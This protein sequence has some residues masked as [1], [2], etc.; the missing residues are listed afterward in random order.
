MPRS[1][2]RS[3]SSVLF[4]FAKQI[5]KAQCKR[6]LNQAVTLSLF[7]WLAV[8]RNIRRQAAAQL[9]GQSS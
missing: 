9:Q 5:L 8:L 1:S 3:L 4:D 7:R 2:P 6:C